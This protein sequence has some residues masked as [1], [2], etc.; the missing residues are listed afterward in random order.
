MYET[1]KYDDLTL[2][3]LEVPK[4]FPNG[5]FMQP[6]SPPEVTDIN[7]ARFAESMVNTWRMEIDALVGT[8]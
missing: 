8:D 5:F 7:G 3:I 2:Y 4:I 1:L 6:M